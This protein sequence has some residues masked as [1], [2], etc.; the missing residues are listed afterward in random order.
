[1]GQAESQIGL[2][3]YETYHVEIPD[4]KKFVREFKERA[5]SGKMT[6]EEFVAHW[7]PQGLP[8]EASSRVFNAFDK[9][10]SGTLELQ[11][12]LTYVAINN[13]TSTVEQKLEASFMVF[14]AS[15]DGTLTREEVR[16]MLVLIAQQQGAADEGAIRFI[17]NDAV[18]KI[19]AAVDT[20][21]N[22]T[23]DMAEF[24]QGFKEQPALCKFF[25]I[26]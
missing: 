21:K 25:K 23:L 19:F 6:L 2:E 13:K 16:A 18:P 22:N 3:I 7:Q 26:F 12:F 20:N 4:I 15:G 1:M 11:E 24:I 17:E 14:D 9:D 8:R 10:H 5:P